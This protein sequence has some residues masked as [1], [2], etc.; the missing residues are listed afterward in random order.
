MKT[1]WEKP[2]LV[3][4]VRGRVEES[5]LCHC[6]I[7]YQRGPDRTRYHCAV[8]GGANPCEGENAS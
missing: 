6:K 5:V 7:W 2:E 1:A 3:V 4:L 8:P